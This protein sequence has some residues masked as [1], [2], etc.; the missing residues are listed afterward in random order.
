MPKF[1]KGDMLRCKPGFRESDSDSGD[2]QGGGGGYTPGLVFEV[3]GEPTGSS[4]YHNKG[5]VYW[6]GKSGNGVYEVALELASNPVEVTNNY[7][8]Y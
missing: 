8:I 6:G 2:Q 3:R 5:S 1:K 4:S 7:Q